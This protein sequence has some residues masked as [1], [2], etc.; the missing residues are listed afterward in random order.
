MHGI[1]STI[2]FSQVTSEDSDNRRLSLAIVPK[3]MNKI[4]IYL[5]VC[6]IKSIHMLA[7]L[8][9]SYGTEMVKLCLW[10]CM[11]TGNH[12]NLILQALDI[13]PRATEIHLLK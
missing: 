1:F 8:A 9:G 11:I 3:K 6:Q 4:Y 10:L 13:A 12:N 2:F 7:R 5:I